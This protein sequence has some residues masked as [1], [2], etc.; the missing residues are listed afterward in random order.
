MGTAG[1]QEQTL[2]TWNLAQWADDVKTFCD[3]LGIERPVVYGASFGGMV[4][5]A[6]VTRHPEH[7]AKLILVSTEAAGY[8][9]LD[10]RVAL[11]ER[12]GGP[13]VGTLARRRFLEGQSDPATLEAWARLSVPPVHAKP[14]RSSR[15]AARD[16]Q[17]RGPQVV[18]ASG[19]GTSHVQFFSYAVACESVRHLS[20]AVK[21]IR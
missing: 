12:L 1:V 13:E 5:L 14:K 7:C 19:W 6:Y 2:S 17:S 3:A 11:F 18:Y 16:P 20:S 8:S 10:R 4:A 15:D 21:T 9:H